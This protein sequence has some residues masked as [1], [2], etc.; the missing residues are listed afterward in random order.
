MRSVQPAEEMAEEVLRW[1]AIAGF[2]NGVEDQNQKELKTICDE[3]LLGV[4]EN[5]VVVWNTP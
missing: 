3:Y 1:R 2:W 4:F 5:D